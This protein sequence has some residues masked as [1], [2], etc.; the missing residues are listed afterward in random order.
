MDEA[1]RIG[2]N[3]YGGYIKEIELDKDGNYIYYEND[4]DRS[5]IPHIIPL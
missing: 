1:S 4:H 2:L 5:S 3:A